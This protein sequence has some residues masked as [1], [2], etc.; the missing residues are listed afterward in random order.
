[1]N[2]AEQIV[3]VVHGDTQ[4]RA[5]LSELL[6]ANGLRAITFR[7]A[8]D[9]IAYPK[10]DPPACLILDVELPDANGLDL[11]REVACDHPAVIFVTSSV[12]VAYSVRAIKAG[13]VDFLTIP[14]DPQEV[15]CSVRVAIARHSSLREERRRMDE[16]RQRLARLTAREREVMSLVVSGMIN[17]QVARELNLREITVQVHRARV[18]EKMQASSFAE[19]VRLA[20]MLRIPLRTA[21]RVRGR[22]PMTRNPTASVMA[23]D[24]R[25]VSMPR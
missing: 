5:S 7:C 13:A 14:F 22:L 16:L 3:F 24:G 11:Q 20:E 17:K 23:Y 4:V 18:M 6:A 10:P 1:M 9:Y 15:V 25:A 21:V 12:N 8:A 19:L 2:Q